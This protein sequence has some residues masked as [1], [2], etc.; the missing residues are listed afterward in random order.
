MPLSTGKCQLSLPD[1][2]WDKMASMIFTVLDG[3]A[4]IDGFKVNRP[5]RY[6]MKKIG[7]VVNPI[8]GMGGRVGLKGTDGV[9]EEALSRGAE[10]RAPER[11][12]EALTRLKEAYT[13]HRLK[14]EVTWLTS[15][16]DMGEK[17]LRSMDVEKWK[18]E[19]LEDHGKRTTAEDTKELVMLAIDRGAELI[20]FCGGDG[21]ARDVFEVAKQHPIFGIPSGVKMH[22]GV[23]AIDPTTAGELLEFYIRGEMTTGEGEIMDLDEDRYRKGEWNIRLFGV[24]RTLFEPAFIQTGKFMVQE[25]E[26]E[27]FISEISDDIFERMEEEPDTVFILGPGGT[28]ESIGKR[29]GI[30][31]THLGVDMVRNGVQLGKDLDERKIESILEEQFESGAKKACI[32]VS[33][34]GGQGFFLGRGNLQISPEVIRMVGI[35][36]III[37]SVPQKLDRTDSLRVDTGD[38]QLDTRIKERGS[39]KVLTGYRTYRIKKIK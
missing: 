26:V 29:M 38:H 24:G 18:I 2:P 28:L 12:I 16:G 22:S 19:I 30:D 6:T 20:V 5:I 34:I 9:V 27:V 21:T 14:E 17:E 39:F 15:S 10:P 13:R 3:G 36:N 1:L 8:A 4:K 33:P 11:A 37:A 7:F 35:D 32:V 31:K 25:Q 23:F